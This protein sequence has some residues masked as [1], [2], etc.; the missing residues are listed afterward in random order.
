ME[1]M[2]E[3]TNKKWERVN[4]VAIWFKNVINST[5][6]AISTSQSTQNLLTYTN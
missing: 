2:K 5:K 4:I 6:I 1:T 3:R